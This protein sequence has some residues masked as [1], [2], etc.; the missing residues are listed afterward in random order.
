MEKYCVAL[1]NKVAAA[2]TLQ[3]LRQVFKGN[4]VF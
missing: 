1:L 4:L 3:M 2:T